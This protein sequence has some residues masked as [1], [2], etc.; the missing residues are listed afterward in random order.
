M[1]W[2]RRAWAD[3]AGA[4]F[5][6]RCPS[7]CAPRPIATRQPAVTSEEKVEGTYERIELDS[8]ELEAAEVLVSM[9]ERRMMLDDF[10]ARRFIPSYAFDLQQNQ[11]TGGSS[12]QVFVPSLLPLIDTPRTRRRVHGRSGSN[13]P[14]TIETIAHQHPIHLNSYTAVQTH[15]FSVRHLQPRSDTPFMQ[16]RIREPRSVGGRTERRN[17]EPIFPAHFRLLHTETVSI[18]AGQ[19]CWGR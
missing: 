5:R 18:Y 7:R 14:S 12:K 16:I 17:A 10:F 3:A 6:E 19:R 9:A 2:A 1:A 13:H 15:L 11:H 4:T 8:P